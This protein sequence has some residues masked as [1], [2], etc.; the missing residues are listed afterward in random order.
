MPLRGVI[1]DLD[2]TLVDSRLDFDAIR[3]DLG[4]PPGEP[5]LEAIGRMPKGE[6]REHSLR[7]LRRHEMRGAQQATV[8]PGVAEFLAALSE[9]GIPR[10]VLTR[11]SRESTEMTLKRLGL[12]LSPVMT[13]DDVPPKP[14]PTG[15]T[16][17][18][19]VWGVQPEEVVYIGDFLFDIQ[20]GRNA[21]VRTMLYVPAGRPEY[22][23]QADFLAK[24]FR[25][26]LRILDRLIDGNPG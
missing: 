22:A 9:R 15:L 3:R 20:A 2:G 19:E 21:G 14:D 24:N 11:N 26:S 16:A 23:A 5:I 12:T 7:I 8:M 1:F 18:C 6:R 13:R 10:G 4:L 17:I 25:E